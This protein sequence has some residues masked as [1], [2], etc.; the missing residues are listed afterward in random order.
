MIRRMMTVPPASSRVGPLRKIFAGDPYRKTRFHDEKGNLVDAG[1]WLYFPLVVQ[2]FLARALFD[3]LY[4]EPWW[5]FC[6]KR[7]VAEILSRDMTV[8]EFGSG[9]STLWLAQRVGRL[10]AIEDNPAWHERV[11]QNIA[12]MGLDNVTLELRNAADYPDVSA[13]PD[14]SVDFCVIDGLDRGR[15]AAAILPKIKPGGW[16]YLDNA[17]K[18][19]NL[20]EDGVNM[21]SAEA[22]LRRHIPESDIRMFTGFTIGLVNT[23][24][25]MLCRCHRAH[26][27]P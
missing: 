21:R 18:D 20:P 10:L 11:K 8:V 15:C 26:A 23:H 3:K 24:Q 9:Q 1:E 6:V 16:I 5:T 14:G 12:R 25:G 13:I 7:R 4:V 27:A 19:S 17:D 22:T 2:R